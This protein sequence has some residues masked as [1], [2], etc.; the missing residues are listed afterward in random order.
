[1]LITI[2]LVGDPDRTLALR[3]WIGQLSAIVVVWSLWP[4][5]ATLRPSRPPRTLEC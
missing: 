1:M 2:A 4:I 3:G 5:V